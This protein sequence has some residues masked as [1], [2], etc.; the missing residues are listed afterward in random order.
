MLKYFPLIF[1][2]ELR[3]LQHTINCLI[4][5][6]AKQRKEEPLLKNQTVYFRQIVLVKVVSP[7]HGYHIICINSFLSIH[8]HSTY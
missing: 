4:A 8:I 7:G 3:T 1:E 2:L 6:S 5:E